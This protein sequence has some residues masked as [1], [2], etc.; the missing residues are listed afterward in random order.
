MTE[1][2]IILLEEKCF[3]KPIGFRFEKLRNIYKLSFRIGNADP[4]LI[5]RVNDY[6]KKYEELSTTSEK[7]KLMKN[8]PKENL[9]F[10]MLLL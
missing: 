2:Y 1:G 10:A 5:L 6:R 8:I 7:G 3:E 9:I 4:I